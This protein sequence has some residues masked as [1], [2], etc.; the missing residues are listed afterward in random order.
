MPK[1]Q[2]S[3]NTVA[4]Y[5]TWDS[6]I[7]A[8]LLVQK[9]ITFGEILVPTTNNDHPEVVFVEN[10]PFESGRAALL[11]TRNGS[12]HDA[13]DLTGGKYNVRSGVHE[14]GGGAAAVLADGSFLFTDYNPKAFDVL[15]TSLDDEPHVVTPEEPAHRYADFGPHP[16]DAN[17]ALA[18][19]EDHTIDEPSKVVNSLVCL[20][21]STTP[22]TVNILLA[23]KQ[24][25]RDATKTPDDGS[26][27]DFYTFPR[28]SP[29]GKFVAWVS[30]Y[31]PSMPWWG[32]ELW[33]ARFERAA[34]GTPTLSEARPVRVGPAGRDE[35]LQQP[36]WGIP[37]DPLSTASE[38]LFTS[39]HTDFANLYTVKVDLNAQQQLAVS[40]PKPVLPE[41]VK[42]DFGPPCWTL[43]NSSYAPLTPDLLVVTVTDGAKDSLGLINLRRPRLIGLSSPFVG[44]TQLRRLTATSFV[45]EA[46]RDDEPSTLVS[47]D[48]RGLAANGYKI[49]DDNIRV[50]KRSSDV[51]SDGTISKDLLSPGEE[52]EFPT[53]LPDGTPSTAHAIVFPPKNPRYVAPAGTSPPCMIT[54]HGGPTHAAH[55][56]LSLPT[57]FW[58]SR[59][60][61]V[62]SVNYGG[63]TGYGRD[64][65]NRLM[66]QWGVVDI[67]DCISAAEYLGSSASGSGKCFGELSAEE[68][69]R[70]RRQLKQTRQE[71][72]AVSAT[73]LDN[74]SVQV[75]LKNTERA[76]GWWDVLV[77]LGVAA[78]F[79]TSAV[80][81][82]GRQVAAGTALAWLWSKMRRVDTQSLTAIPSVGL[83]I[84]TTRGLRLPFGVADRNVLA[85]QSSRLIPRD[86]ILD[87][88]VGEGFRRWSV[89]DY[90]ALVEKDGKR[91]DAEDPQRR[92]GKVVNLFSELSPRL[93]TAERVYRILYPALF[94]DE[95]K[96]RE[97]GEVA[98]AGVKSA[99][100]GKD[101][102][103]SKSKSKSKKSK[104]MPLADPNA[105][106]ISGGSS[107]G[108]T[109]LLSLCRSTV[110]AAGTS[111]YGICD[112]AMLA[113][114]SHK[115]ESQYPFQ[116]IGGRPEEIPEVYKERSPIYLADKIAVPLL[117][118]QG[119]E[120]KVVPPNQS[121]RIVEK[122]E[123][124]GG[125]VR[126]LRFEGEGH[127]E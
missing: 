111:R 79:A 102:S 59:G 10:R 52:I 29:N 85:T 26:D 67:Q 64:Y 96:G 103:K 86:R 119:S 18:I 20:D 21:M 56:G 34:D 6:P 55:A 98:G 49:S 104:R 127:G 15:R 94:G 120:D 40:E 72:S 51:V 66:A 114:D 105:I 62:C 116:L 28:F 3:T 24:G 58:T 9:R 68:A 124:S 32:T 109:V 108:Y 33:I 118:Q 88:Y 93:S 95:G 61:M 41:P 12:A 44:V 42:Q 37:R 53:E 4:P 45:L 36:V 87:L 39:D 25:P 31:H 19:Q 16:T 83:Q 106:V 101:K 69:Q 76:W 126:Y 84:S 92:A 13:T 14:Y 46:T 121:E 1:R 60:W 5:G 115:F 113:A 57:Q 125:K 47:V 82:L 48:L 74:G 65:M 38:L 89:V 99:G 107:G 97:V 122:V 77:G 73:K 43:N 7:T 91:S 8:D 123:R 27:R 75:T 50:I 100:T 17:F 54:I 35:A 81:S 63:S 78:P 22:A 80:P 2:T 112:L 110:F 117:V 70:V 71:R 30:W 23:G 11:H 90:L